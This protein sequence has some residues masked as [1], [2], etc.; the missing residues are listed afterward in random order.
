MYNAVAQ[1]AKMETPDNRR[2]GL[3]FSHSS[4][5][6]GR[7]NEVATR[8]API[9]CRRLKLTAVVLLATLFLG[10]VR[11]TALTDHGARVAAAAGTQDDIRAAPPDETSK[12][13][14][15]SPWKVVEIL[16][17]IFAVSVLLG[18]WYGNSRSPNFDDTR[19]ATS[20]IAKH[21]RIE[22]S[23]F[24]K[25]TRGA[26]GTLQ[27][28]VPIYIYRFPAQAYTYVYDALRKDLQE[29][30]YA[31]ERDGAQPPPRT[32]RR[33][34]QAEAVS[35]IALFGEAPHLISSSADLQTVLQGATGA[36][37]VRT[38]LLALAAVVTGFALGYRLG[39]S[40]E[41][42]Y[43]SKSFQEEI[44]KP[45]FWEVVALEHQKR[46]GWK[47]SQLRGAIL[48]LSLNTGVILNLGEITVRKVTSTC[49]LASPPGEVL[50]ALKLCGEADLAARLTA[51]AGQLET[52]L[53]G[54]K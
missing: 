38:I 45:A 25:Q 37:K 46:D 23:G 18:G 12:P 54:L 28:L 31:R 43:Q 22:P 52:V 4:V 39:Y 47:F 50:Q 24:Y 21:V 11:A 30:A 53:S 41:F 29:L 26:D 5:V 3:E 16:A 14:T 49:R 8:G 20:Y 19:V 17:A 13:K 10:A 44:K 48:V 51:Q 36:D 2:R 1:D 35:A 34:S 15:S 6:I 9:L 7:P 27:T 33:A 42:D 32:K 40:E